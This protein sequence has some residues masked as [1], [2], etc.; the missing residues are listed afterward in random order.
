MI[1]TLRN[2]A[3]NNYPISCKMSILI[4]DIMDSDFLYKHDNP[5]PPQKVELRDILRDAVHKKP[6]IFHDIVQNYDIIHL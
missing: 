1:G 2:V 5:I 3:E 6:R 4:F